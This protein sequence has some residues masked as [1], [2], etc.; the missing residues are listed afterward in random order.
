MVKA[1]IIG[2]FVIFS[3]FS[4]FSIHESYGSIAVNGTTFGTATSTITVTSPITVDSLATDGTKL[5]TRHLPTDELKGYYFDRTGSSS[6]YNMYLT[7]ISSTE[8]DFQVGTQ[9][10]T[11]VRGFATGTQLSSVTVDGN[12]VGTTLSNNITYFLVNAGSVIRELFDVSSSGGGSSTS[13]GGSPIPALPGAGLQFIPTPSANITGPNSVGTIVSILPKSYSLQPGASFTDSFQVNWNTPDNFQITNIQISPSPIV[14]TP[15]SPFP[16]L[17]GSSSGLSNG[18]ILY[19]LTIPTSFCN[20]VI[21]DH[22]IKPITY[23]IPI[24]IQGTI[25]SSTQ[26]QQS[27]TI[28]VNMNQNLDYSYLVVFGIAGMAIVGIIAQ[29]YRQGSKKRNKKTGKSKLEKYVDSERKS[30]KKKEGSLMKKLKVLE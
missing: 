7:G 14:I 23:N 3:L 16:V 6:I 2:L 20:N 25:G 27:T 26:V 4:I 22:C 19:S 13:G 9:G 30:G 10:L 11:D 21:L 28:T 18:K 15:Q 8:I 5:T 29:I 24:I 12:Q 1:Q 17:A